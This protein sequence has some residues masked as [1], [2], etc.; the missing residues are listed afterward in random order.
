MALLREHDLGRA[1]QPIR[2]ADQLAR[3]APSFVL[4]RALI[5]EGMSY[6]TEP[7]LPHAMG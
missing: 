4:R 6:P 3:L 2:M 5:S 7:R 1:P